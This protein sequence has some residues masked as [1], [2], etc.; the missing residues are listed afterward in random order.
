M[1]K[2]MSMATWGLMGLALMAPP[3]G[4]QTRTWGFSVDAVHE[5]GGTPGSCTLSN[6]GTD[7]LRFDTVMLE[8]V[9]PVSMPQYGVRFH[10]TSP[11][12]SYVLN[13]NNG[14]CSQVPNPKGVRVNPAQS[15]TLS[16]FVIDINGDP[17]ILTKRAGGLALGDTMQARLIFQ[18]SGGRGRDTLLVNGT[19]Q[20]TSLR[21]P[22]VFQA[23]EGA[24]GGRRFDL[25]GRRIEKL[26]EGVRSPAVPLVSPG[27]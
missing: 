2:R 13:C 24:K 9:R 22:S 3:I 6:Q 1:R 8:I 14:A 5:S 21:L 25:R 10:M 11:S 27:K 12:A 18:A 19:Q 20:T 15:V 26:P 4:A 17:I 16:E 23:P 7:T